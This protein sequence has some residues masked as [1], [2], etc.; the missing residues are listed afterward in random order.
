MNLVRST[1]AI[2]CG[3]ALNACGESDTGQP[4][5]ANLVYC[6]NPEAA[7]PSCSSG[8]YS[9][10]DDSAL[11]AKLAGCAANGCHGALSATTWTLDLSGSVEDALVALTTYA[12][13]SPY[14]LV[15]DLDPDCSQMLSE[16]TSKPVGVRMPATGNYWSAAETDCFRSYLHEL[17]PQ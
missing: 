15:D 8:G 13:R 6:D 1:L 17:Y 12:D 7:A 2:V 4:F 3:L 16:V 11:R 10:A 9:L 14:F 5:A